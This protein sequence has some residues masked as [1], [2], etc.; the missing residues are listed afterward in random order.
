MRKLFHQSPGLVSGLFLF[1]LALCGY[2][3][4]VRVSRTLSDTQVKEL[5]APPQELKYLHFGHRY[6]MSDL[7]WIRAIQDFDYCESPIRKNLCRGNSWLS[8]TLDLVVTLDPEFRMAYSAGGMALSVVISDILGASRL[9]DRGLK[10]FPQDWILHYK[11]AYHSL[12]E[13]NDPEMAA[14]RMQIA[15]KL[16]APDWV[17]ALA[18][19]LYTDAGKKE[20]AVKVLEEATALGLPEK[21]LNRI[22]EKMQGDSP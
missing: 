1:S 2:V 10:A 20:L 15:A 18:G 4:S 22:R 16:G 7:F 21:I 14:Q 12:Y 3:A 9:F 19:R 5:I 11:A 8:Q 6:L 17:Y 13:E